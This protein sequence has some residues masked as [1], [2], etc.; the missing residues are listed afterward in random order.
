MIGDFEEVLAADALKVFIR[1]IH[2]LVNSV[3]CNNIDIRQG[4]SSGSKLRSSVKVLLV[5]A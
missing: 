2:I 1:A 4:F 3:N 5:L